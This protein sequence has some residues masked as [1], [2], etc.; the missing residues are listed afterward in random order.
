MSKWQ[1]W[2]DAEERAARVWV[3]ETKSAQEKQAAVWEA[4][5][6]KRQWENE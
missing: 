6:A 1:V 5:C 4:V 2:Q 3:D